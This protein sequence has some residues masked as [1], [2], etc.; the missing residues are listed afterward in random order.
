MTPEQFHTLLVA[1]SFLSLRFAKQY[2]NHDLPIDAF[3][4]RV[5]LNQS[6]DYHATADEV[7]YPSD[8]GRTVQR[9]TEREV[10]ALL[11][12]D[13]K[14]PEWIDVSAEAVGPGVTVFRLLCCGRY[15]GDNSKM[16]YASR[17]LGPFGVKSPVLPPRFREGERFALKAV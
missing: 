17:G 1:A 13:G 4:Y 8:D 11:C 10:V 3:E 9:V 6:C 12:R 7:L 15:T 2:V 14:C 5:D 16:Y